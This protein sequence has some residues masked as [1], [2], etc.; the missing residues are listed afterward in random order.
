[1]LMQ[2]VYEHASTLG[3]LPR[4][5]NAGYVRRGVVKFAIGCGREQPGLLR[6]WRPEP[7]FP[8]AAWRE[9]LGLAEGEIMLFT[10]D[11]AEVVAREALQPLSRPG[12]RRAA[13]RTS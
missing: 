9:V 3:I 4:P 13:E 8:A 5:S 7:E 6:G 1:M 11:G 12:L 2:L 10:A